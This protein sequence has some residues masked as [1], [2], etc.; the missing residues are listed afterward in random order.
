MP[1]TQDPERREAVKSTASQTSALQSNLVDELIKQGLSSG[2]QYESGGKLVSGLF[3]DLFNVGGGLAGLFG[4]EDAPGIG[5]RLFGKQKDDTEQKNKLIELAAE[6]EKVK[7]EAQAARD[8]ATTRKEA[9]VESAEAEASKPVKET[10]VKPTPVEE[11][12]E[13][14]DIQT[15][16]TLAQSVEGAPAITQDI[17]AETIDKAITD[18]SYIPQLL[19]EAN[20]GKGP[21]IDQ[22]RNLAKKHF[23]TQLEATGSLSQNQTPEGIFGVLETGLRESREKQLQ[24]IENN[25]NTP[26]DKAKEQSAGVLTSI[27]SYGARIKAVRDA[28]SPV[29]ADQMEQSLT[30]YGYR[31]K[32]EGLLNQVYDTAYPRKAMFTPGSS[33]PLY[34]APPRSAFPDMKPSDAAAIYREFKESM[35]DLRTQTSEQA[36][37]A[38]DTFR[39]RMNDTLGKEVYK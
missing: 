8:V 2:K 3:E 7:L 38:W 16:A 28:L 13:T 1:R 4:V 22:A 18:D 5:T 37:K 12:A 39:K 15:A 14:S 35:P 17:K 31:Q 23:A 32:Y 29:L 36:R 6:L 30:I 9:D 19:K 33:F 34:S 11:A 27:G 24:Q 20:E 21:L 26:V 10:P 25:P